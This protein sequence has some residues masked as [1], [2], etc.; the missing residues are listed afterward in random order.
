ME[1]FVFVFTIVQNFFDSSEKREI[2][3]LFNVMKEVLECCVGE[4]RI[5]LGEA[6]IERYS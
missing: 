4:Y 5:S 1:F 3:P 2:H 6:K